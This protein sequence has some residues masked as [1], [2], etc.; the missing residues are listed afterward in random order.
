MMF[1]SVISGG[2]SG[3]LGIVDTIVVQLS[4]KSAALILPAPVHH[5]V[6]GSPNL[7]CS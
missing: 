5:A 1:V 6:S 4:L 3:S 2:S 7:R